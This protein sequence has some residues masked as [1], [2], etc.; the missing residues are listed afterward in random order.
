MPAVLTFCVTLSW[1]AQQMTAAPRPNVVVISADDQG[2]GDLSANGITN[3]T[4][5]T[6]GRCV[7]VR[8]A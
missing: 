1:V 8:S 4:S 3:L 7:W 2:W 5:R 6:S